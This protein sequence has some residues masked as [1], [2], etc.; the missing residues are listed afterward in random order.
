MVALIT[1][2]GEL[3]LLVPEMI[4]QGN[5]LNDLFRPCLYFSVVAP[6]T[7]SGDLFSGFHRQGP[8]FFTLHNMVG[9]ASV[10]EF[11]GNGPMKAGSMNL[12]FKTMAFKTGIIGAVADGHLSSLVNGICPEMTINTKRIRE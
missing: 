12:G 5:G 6:Q 2:M 9:I 3:D 1:I 7:K 10:A 8:C 4:R 11:T